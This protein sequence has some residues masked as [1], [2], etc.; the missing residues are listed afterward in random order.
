MAEMQLR[1]GLEPKGKGRSEME[2]LLANTDH[3]AFKKL[4]RDQIQIR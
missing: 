4:H 2:H 1:R 3:I